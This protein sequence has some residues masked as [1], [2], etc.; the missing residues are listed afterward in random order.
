VAFTAPDRG[1][2]LTRLM[3]QAR[4]ELERGKESFGHPCTD[5][6]TSCT[7][8]W[9]TYDG[10]PQ[11]Q[12]RVQSRFRPS[13]KLSSSRCCPTVQQLLPFILLPPPD[14]DAKHDVSAQSTPSRH[15]FMRHSHSGRGPASG[16]DRRREHAHGGSRRSRRCSCIPG[17]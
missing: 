15:S 3:P 8:E 6:L 7:V 13:S 12:A 17:K 16:P 9:S 2:H 10:T 4:L 14:A 11:C 1:D 5:V